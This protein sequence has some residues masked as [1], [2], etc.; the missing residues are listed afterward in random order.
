MTA[1]LAVF[2]F[3]LAVEPGAALVHA[4]DRFAVGAEHAG[5]GMRG[6]RDVSQPL[7]ERGGG[8]RGGEGGGMAAAAGAGLAFTVSAQQPAG[9]SP[10]RVSAADKPVASIRAV[11]TQISALCMM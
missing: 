4:V 6:T 10:P 7:R 8:A 1:A 11:R 3:F 2:L 5:R 9:L